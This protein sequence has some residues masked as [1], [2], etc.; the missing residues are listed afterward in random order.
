MI[1]RRMKAMTSKS[2]MIRAMF[3]E[4]NKLA[5]VYGRENVFDF[6]LGNPFVEPPREVTSC[7]VNIVQNEKA[8]DIHGYMPNAGYLETR[9]AV[10]DDLNRKFG[11]NYTQENIIMTAGAAGGLNCVFQSLLN[12]DDEVIVCSPFFT[13]YKNYVENWQGR[14]VIV[15]S[16]KNGFLLPV[17]AIEKAVTKN[18]KA[19]IINNPNNPTGVLYSLNTIEQLAIMLNKKQ[20]ELKTTIY[21]ISDEPYREITY[22]NQKAPWIPDSYK[23]TIVVYSWSKSLSIPGERIGYVAVNPKAE[24]AT[25]LGNAITISNRIIGFVNAPS[26]MQLIVSKCLNLETNIEFYDNNRR[27]LYKEL[28]RI[29]YECIY[30]QGAF[31]LWIKAPCSEMRFIEIA[32]KHNVLLVPGSAFFCEGYVRLAYCVGDRMIKKAIPAFEQIWHDIQM[33]NGDGGKF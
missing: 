2:S 32:K 24:E 10:A 13:E 4:G 31:Y 27:F 14:L 19:I 25:L 7:L 8:A 28:K 3:E 30:P 17:N 22:D 29:G 33:D 18:T 9:K 21:I 23:N 6:S 26:L 12:P 5:A 11:G 15:D 1:S 16:S 20:Q